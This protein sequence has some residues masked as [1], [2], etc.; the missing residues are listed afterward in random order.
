MDT[1][2]CASKFGIPALAIT[3]MSSFGGAMAAYFEGPIISTIS[4]VAG[5]CIANAAL[6]NTI[7]YLNEQYELKQ[8]TYLFMLAASNIVV[9]GGSCAAAMHLNVLGGAG[10]AVLGTMMTLASAHL[11]REGSLQQGVARMSISARKRL[12]HCSIGLERK[13]NFS[14]NLQRN[15]ANWRDNNSS[16]QHGGLTCRAFRNYTQY[17]K[18]VLKAQF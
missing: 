17:F 16:L 9:I 14:K 11:I 18:I 4:L 12:E 6:L 10:L 3:A 2:D 1:R 15:I 5:T 7:E 8:S 13:K